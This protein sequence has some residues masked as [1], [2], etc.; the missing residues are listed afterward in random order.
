M[1][2]WRGLTLE[3]PRGGGG[4]FPQQSFYSDCRLKWNF[5]EGCGERVQTR[6][7]SMGSMDN[8]SFLKNCCPVSFFDYASNLMIFVVTSLLFILVQF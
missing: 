7:P 6:N 1:Q 2:L 5:P 8:F 4:R 3:F